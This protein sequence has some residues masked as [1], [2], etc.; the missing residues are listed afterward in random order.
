MHGSLFRLKTALVCVLLTGAAAPLAANPEEAPYLAEN[1]AAMTKM[2]AAMEIEPSGDVDRDFVAM[3]VPHYQGAI[4]MAQAQL[5]NGHNARLRRIAQEI[6]VTQQQ[7]IVAMRSALGEALPPSA[8][9]VDQPS[10]GAS[11]DVQPS[12][13][14][15]RM[16][17]EP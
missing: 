7:E 10:S 14:S 2:M 12:H 17:E 9:S 15:V 16:N 4:E 3:M 8:I 13:H 5:R 11:T 6:I 1:D